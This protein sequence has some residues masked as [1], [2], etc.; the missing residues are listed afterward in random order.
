MIS[1]SVKSF[2][3]ETTKIGV[4]KLFNNFLCHLPAQVRER[5]YGSS[6]RFIWVPDCSVAN[7]SEEEILSD[8]RNQG[9]LHKKI[10]REML[11]T[12]GD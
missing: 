10:L 12:M 9:P 3:R 1:F 7:Y 2:S 11:E 5:L 6:G 8:V 4:D